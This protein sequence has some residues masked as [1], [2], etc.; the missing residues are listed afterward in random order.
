MSAD[1]NA[2]AS[3]F[4]A[5]QT[6]TVALSVTASSVRAALSQP[7]DGGGASYGA[8]GYQQY[9]IYN[10]G[11]VAV[12][13]NFGGAAVV[14]TLPVAGGAIGDYQ[15]APGATVVVSVKGG[16]AITNVAAIGAGAGPSVVYVTPGN[17]N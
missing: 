6:A 4:L 7:P 13:V 17:G 1:I 11:S 8:A 15:V 5:A 3:P 14:A 2:S 12:F 10:S 16:A 9:Q